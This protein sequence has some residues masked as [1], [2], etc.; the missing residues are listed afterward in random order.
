MNQTN[1]ADKLYDHD[2]DNDYI[3][4]NF[5]N[6]F[7]N[8][9]SINTLNTETLNTETLNTETLNN[10]DINYE[11]TDK[12]KSCNSQ[13]NFDEN[14]LYNQSTKVYDKTANSVG[15]ITHKW[16]GGDCSAV[17]HAFPLHAALTPEEQVHTNLQILNYCT[18]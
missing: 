18:N 6:I 7:Y 4:S 1:D 12:D 17:L 8:L 2:N 14:Q 5:N 15:N 11:Q 16:L 13:D 10:V 3:E 9:C